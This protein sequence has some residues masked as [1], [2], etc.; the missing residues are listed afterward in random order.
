MHHPLSVHICQSPGNALELSELNY[1]QDERDDR[2]WALETYELEP[3]HIP[4]RFDELVDI[5][6]VHP[7][8][9]HHELVS[10]HR[11]SQER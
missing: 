5:P 7:L 6:I 10:A 3:I 8:R 2:Q 9:C 11:H 1:H 4:M